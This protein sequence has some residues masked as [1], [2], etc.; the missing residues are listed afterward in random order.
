MN[1]D[2]D[3]YMGLSYRIEVFEDKEE[4]GYALRCPQLPGCVTCAETVGKGF[5][6]IEDAKK[7]WISAGLENGCE[8]P[9]PADDFSDE[10]N[11]YDT[12]N[13]LNEAD[14]IKARTYINGLRL[15]ETG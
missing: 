9:E 10:F 6:L 2:I 8:I 14:K 4:G 12:Y 11:L 3:Y 15:S 1:K 7:C 13:K 5:E